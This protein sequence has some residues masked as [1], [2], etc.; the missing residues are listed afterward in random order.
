[1]IPSRRYPDSFPAASGCRASPS[2]QVSLGKVCGILKSLVGM[3]YC[4]RHGGKFVQAGKR[5]V[6]S[7]SG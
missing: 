1:M 2:V 3:Q 7:F 5:Q 4:T 6:E